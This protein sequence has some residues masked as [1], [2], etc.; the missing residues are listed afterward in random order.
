MARIAPAAGTLTHTGD[1][2]GLPAAAAR[3][4]SF[5]LRAHD[6]WKNG[7]TLHVAAWPLSMPLSGSWIVI[8]TDYLKLASEWAGGLVRT[9]DLFRDV[10]TA[11]AHGVYRMTG[12][13]KPR[14]RGTTGLAI[15]IG[16]SS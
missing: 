2:G 14:K 4:R 11:E 12:G 8:T 15:R 13:S 3:L 1:A 5:G 16:A 10:A 7:A 9:A 6:A